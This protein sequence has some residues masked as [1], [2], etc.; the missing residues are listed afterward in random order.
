MDSML[1][2][3]V[4]RRR[5]EDRIT[6]RLESGL[7]AISS[8]LILLGTWW[9]SPGVQSSGTEGL[10]FRVQGLDQDRALESCLCSAPG[11]QLNWA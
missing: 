3:S 10:E 6:S 11:Q 2:V 8:K 7:A 4:C 9:P 5:F 1:F